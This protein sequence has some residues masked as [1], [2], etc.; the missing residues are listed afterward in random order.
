MKEKINIHEKATAMVISPRKENAEKRRNFLWA[1]EGSGRL[2]NDL[3]VGWELPRQ[4]SSHLK[5]GA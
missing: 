2:R 4:S 5:A 1:R 3:E